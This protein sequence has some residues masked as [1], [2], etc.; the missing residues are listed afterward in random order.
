ML[1]IQL[2]IPDYSK[3]VKD[4]GVSPDVASPCEPQSA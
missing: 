2:K 1:M 3:A 4:L